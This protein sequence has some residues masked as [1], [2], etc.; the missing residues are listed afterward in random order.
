MLSDL[1]KIIGRRA[2]SERITNSFRHAKSGIPWILLV[3]LSTTCKYVRFLRLLLNGVK[4]RPVVKFTAPDWGYKVDSGIGLL[5][6][7]TGPP[8]YVAWQTGTTTLQGMPE[9]TLSPCQRLWILLLGRSTLISPVIFC[10]WFLPGV[11]KGWPIF[12][13]GVISHICSI[14]SVIYW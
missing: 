13:C 3:L 7:R 1:I 9:S 2:G 12:V 14:F 11:F 10:Q 8:A 5:T 6:C 4:R